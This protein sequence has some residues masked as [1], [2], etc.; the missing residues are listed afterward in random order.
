MLVTSNFSFSHNVF[1]SYKFLGRRKASLCGNGL[2]AFAEYKNNVAKMM[3]SAFDRV[4]N[5]L[6]IG[7]N[8]GY[9]HFLLFPQCFQKAS[10]FKVVKSGDCVVKSSTQTHKGF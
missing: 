10:C 8:A 5:I 3:I 1:F 2:K 4:E 6:G 7:E 9:Q